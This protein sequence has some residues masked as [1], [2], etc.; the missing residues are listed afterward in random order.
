MRK[1]S[2]EI[3]DKEWDTFVA[4]HKDGSFLQTTLWGKLKS[5]FGWETQKLCLLEDKKINGGCLIFYRNLPFNVRLAYVPYGPL[6]DWNDKELS[7]E[8]LLEIK[9]FSYKNGASVLIIEPNTLESDEIVIFLQ[10]NGFYRSF[11]KNIQPQKTL[12]LDISKS[13][14]EILSG[15]E[16]RA[17]Y[18]IRV[19]IKRGVEVRSGSERDIQIF[20][21]LLKITSERNKFK[22]HP[23][24]YYFQAFKI[25]SQSGYANLLIAEF[26]KEPI[27]AAVIFA[28]PPKAWYIYGASSGSHKEKN[29]NYLLQWEAIKWA[30]SI[31]CTEYDLW[32]TLDEEKFSNSSLSGVYL[33]KRAF[34]GRLVKK[35]GAWEVSL[36]QLRY[37][38][39]R[40]GAIFYRMKI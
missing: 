22:I 3:S 28:I 39:Y 29:P 14:E 21:N 26:K 33:F 23:Q 1:F 20:Y 31:G 25:F 35:M 4:S 37:F 10:N 7:K 16:K 27:A 40:L 36:K 24:N 6:I 8:I 2:S 15:M 11:L 38:I 30:K 13:Q 9:K 18:G 12:I 5:L 32:G 19:A 17:R 34:G